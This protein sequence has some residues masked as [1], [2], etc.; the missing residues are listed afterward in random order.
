MVIFNNFF[1]FGNDQQDGRI[2]FEEFK[3]M[4]TSGA[5]WKMASRQYSR[6]MMSALSIKLFKDKSMELTKSMELN[7]SMELKKSVE[8]KKSG[9]LRI[10]QNQG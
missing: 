1:F 7:K 6:A 10:P 9:Q 4:M 3:A 2:S 5:D 8:L